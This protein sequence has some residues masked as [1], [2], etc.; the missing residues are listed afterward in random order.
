LRILLI[1]D[2]FQDNCEK[3]KDKGQPATPIPTILGSGIIVQVYN[4]AWRRYSMAGLAFWL[5]PAIIRA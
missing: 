5:K 2:S 4:Y 3:E 1:Q